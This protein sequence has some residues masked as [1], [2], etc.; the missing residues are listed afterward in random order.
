MP[1]KRILFSLRTVISNAII[2]YLPIFFVRTFIEIVFFDIFSAKWRRCHH[3]YRVTYMRYICAQYLLRTHFKMS[4][5][6]QKR[7][8]IF[9]IFFFFVVVILIWNNRPFCSRR[10]VFGN[11]MFGILFQCVLNAHTIQCECQW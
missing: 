5:C 7:K 4:I 2:M 10:I 6:I 8:N 3:R 1:S 11:C 9:V